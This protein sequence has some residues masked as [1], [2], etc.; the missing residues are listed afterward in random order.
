MS[1]V[2]LVCSYSVPGYISV[3]PLHICRVSSWLIIRSP[4]PLLVRDPTYRR[5]AVRPSSHQD[6]RMD[7]STSGGRS[8]AFLASIGEEAARLWVELPV[9][10][11]WSAVAA[12]CAWLWARARA[13]VVVPA[14]R[15]LV[16]LSLAMTVMILVEK[17]FICAVCLV[18]RVFRLRP[19]RRY[20]WEPIA[21]SSP[22]SGV[23]TTTHPT[24]LVQ[25]PMYNER[26]VSRARMGGS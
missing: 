16:F 7:A 9:R 12:Q 2:L 26:E 8:D 14:V 13:L 25:I 21:S 24:V 18:V 5:P 3:L 4:L 20:K 19:G 10:V 11:D 22:G 6:R 15:V 17:V 1:Q 23:A